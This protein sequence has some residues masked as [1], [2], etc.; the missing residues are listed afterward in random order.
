MHPNV[1]DE[2]GNRHGRL[3]VLALSGNKRG[4]LPTWTC[5]CDCGTRVEATGTDVVRPTVAAH[6]PHALAHQRASQVLHAA[7][8]GKLEHPQGD[9]QRVDPRSLIAD[10][11]LALGRLVKL[12]HALLNLLLA[13][14]AH[15]AHVQPAR[16]PRLVA[17]QRL[18]AHRA[19]AG[20]EG[21]G[22]A[23]GGGRGGQR[24]GRGQALLRAAMRARRRNVTTQIPDVA[25]RTLE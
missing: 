18:R 6:D 4:P 5:R 25:M 10:G 13:R 1:K 14:V 21:G 17:R 23:A 3:T 11:H 2:T 9:A 19:Q 15:A 24:R 16:V 12:V 7:C 22:G 20:A 8:I